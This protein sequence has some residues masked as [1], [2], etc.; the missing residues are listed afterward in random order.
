[1]DLRIKR[2]V[3]LSPLFDW[4]QFLIHYDANNIYNNK[5][6]NYP[7]P[8]SQTVFHRNSN[9]MEISYHFHLDSDIMIATICI[10]GTA[11]MLSWYAQ[12]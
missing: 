4:V 1:M 7:G 5:Q 12:T 2:G 6:E 9:S 3:N 10:H 11:A 8:L